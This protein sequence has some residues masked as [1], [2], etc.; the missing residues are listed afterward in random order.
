MQAG[1]SSLHKCVVL[2]DIGLQEKIRLLLLAQTPEL[3]AFLLK[4]KSNYKLLCVPI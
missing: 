2:C 4:T 1:A 3:V